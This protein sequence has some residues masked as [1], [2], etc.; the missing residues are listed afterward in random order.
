[1]Y[2]A[3]CK[4]P[5]GHIFSSRVVEDSPDINYFEVEDPICPE[6]GA[7]E[8]EAIETFDDSFDDLY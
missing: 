6:C 7:E 3:T 8:F 2:T 1:M 5:N 4:C